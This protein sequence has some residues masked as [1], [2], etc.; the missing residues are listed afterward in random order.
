MGDAGL[1]LGTGEAR[2]GGAVVGGDMVAVCAVLVLEAREWWLIVT[3]AV[4]EGTTLPTAAVPVPSRV[5]ILAMEAALDMMLAVV[6]CSRQCETGH[7]QCFATWC[8]ERKGCA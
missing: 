3:V 7:R 6:G 5:A 8:R 4:F 2:A 1:P